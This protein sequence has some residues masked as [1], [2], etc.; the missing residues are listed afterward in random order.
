MNGYTVSLQDR[1]FIIYD[2]HFD[3]VYVVRLQDGTDRVS[4]H[5]LVTTPSCDHVTV[6][7]DITPYC[8]PKG[9]SNVEHSAVLIY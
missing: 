2:L 7:G 1:N 6:V 3:C 9:R 4:G 5:V 8:P